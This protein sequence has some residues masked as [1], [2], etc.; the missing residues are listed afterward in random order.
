MRISLG[1][2]AL[3][4]AW[5]APMQADEREKKVFAHYMGCFPAAS[6]ALWY[7]RHV[8]VLN[9]RHES[10]DAADSRG[11]HLRNWDLTPPA[12]Q[13]SLDESADLEI[14]RAM[15][16][17]IDGFAMDAWAGGEQAQQMFEALFRVAEEKDYPFELTVCV[18]MAC[19]GDVAA[20][21]EMLAAHGRSPKLA[22]RDGKPIVFGYLSIFWIE[23]Y[24]AAALKA[25]PEWQAVF[26]QEALEGYTLWN[27]PKLRA[28]PEGWTALGEVFREFDRQ[29]GQA[30]YWHMDLNYFFHEVNPKHVQEDSLVR[31]SGIL[32]RHV[33]ALGG[34]AWLGPRQAEIAK[35]VIAA[36]A[37]W[38]CP[39]GHYQKENIPFEVYA[40]KGTDWLRGSWDAARA[41]NA[42]LLQIIT[43]NDYG[44]NTIVAPSYN[45]RYTLYD[46]TGYYIQW[47]KTGNPPVPDR[48]RLY[49]IY[50]KYPRWVK[51]FPFRSAVYVDGAL[52]VL[53]VLP[54]AATVRLPGRE[55][56]YDAPAG[57]SWKQF[58]VTPGPVA[59]ELLRDGNVVF[60]VESPEP[61]TD[62][63]F[64]EDNGMVC[65]S[66][67]FLRHWKADF[68]ETPPLHYSEYGDLDGDGLP[69]WFEMY[70]FS[71]ERGFRPRAADP[72]EAI[73]EEIEGQ[74][75]KPQF[76][77]WLDFSTA[78]YA[79]PKADPDGD[80]KTNLEEYLG[81][82]DPTLSSAGPDTDV[83]G[84]GGEGDDEEDER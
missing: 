63:P 58:E 31:A 42:T 62:R 7:H 79:E 6:G 8:S 69:N 45:A 41:Q 38:S 24:A 72:D 28:T 54:A 56:E 75:E 33:Q 21:Q 71:K 52:E 53:T 10:R 18:D 78:T 19:G 44:E 15:R 76:T 47:W 2:F 27:S 80:G 66:S 74:A 1:V 35:A 61:I 17:G 70:W 20:V 9:L 14:R 55:V 83:E 25:R 64:R 4:S 51:V 30:I 3:L 60:R 37:E 43:W 40:G 77:R 23:R 26:E 22:R 84:L 46:L 50:R 81:Q 68:G 67:E 49:L 11:G 16:I 29:I 73:D 36:G 32:A 13:L 48:D 39:V 12:L 59:A 5:L 82:T 57:L 65:Y 34:F